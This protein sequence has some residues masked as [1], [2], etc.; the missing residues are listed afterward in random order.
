[1]TEK[2]RRI[3]ETDIS[4]VAPLKD[5]A[6][7]YHVKVFASIYVAIVLRMGEKDAQTLVTGMHERGYIDCFHSREA[8]GVIFLLKFPARERADEFC[9][10]YLILCDEGASF[11]KRAAF[12]VNAFGKFSRRKK[13]L[14]EQREPEDQIEMMN[15]AWANCT[16]E[17]N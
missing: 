11:A 5:F 4:W 2:K 7:D 9:C 1:M 15:H 16:I 17:I 12:C 10:S 13:K 6:F 14:K 3:D 8:N